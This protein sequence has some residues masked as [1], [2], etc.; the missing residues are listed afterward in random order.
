MDDPA[1]LHYNRKVSR[2]LKEA[3]HISD[4][5][6]LIYIRRNYKES[7]GFYNR[8]SL[9]IE[10]CGGYAD[11]KT[12]FIDG[13]SRLQYIPTIELG[14]FKKEMIHTQRIAAFRWLGKTTLYFLRDNFK[15]I[16]KPDL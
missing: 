7:K 8:F 6:I 2:I 14:D 16:K 4:E 15:T 13:K 11:V 9:L 12:K 10:E 1:E 3:P 5:A